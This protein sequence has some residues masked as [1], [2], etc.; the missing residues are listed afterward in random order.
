[1][2]CFIK[3]ADKGFGL[4]EGNNMLAI[5]FMRCIGER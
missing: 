4:P 1:M 2:D 3:A 5:Y